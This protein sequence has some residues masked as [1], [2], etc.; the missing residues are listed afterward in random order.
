MAESES[1]SSNVEVKA[2]IKKLIRIRG[3]HKGTFTKSDPKIDLMLSRSIVNEE[4]LCE[5][6]ALLANLKNRWKIEKNGEKK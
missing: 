2:D 3:G 6:E 1:N 4:Q 5:A